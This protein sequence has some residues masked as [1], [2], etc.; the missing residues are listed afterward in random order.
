MRGKLKKHG[1]TG[2][3]Q[4][5]EDSLGG[6]HVFGAPAESR[7]ETLAKLYMVNM[8]FSCARFPCEIIHIVPFLEPV[9]RLLDCYAQTNRI[10]I[11]SQIDGKVR[12][13]SGSSGWL[14]STLVRKESIIRDC[15]P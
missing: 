5:R 3:I 7:Q 6:Q 1:Q 4:G 15:R 13:Y 10:D 11:R 14:L 2:T 9:D 8:S 12:C